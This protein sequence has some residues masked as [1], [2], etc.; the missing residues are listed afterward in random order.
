[1][2]IKEH[3]INKKTDTR[4]SKLTHVIILVVLFL[5]IIYELIFPQNSSKENNNNRN[6]NNYNFIS[7]EKINL[8]INIIYY[9]LCFIRDLNQK[10]TK[11]SFQIYFHFC[12]SISASIP[13]IYLIKGIINL[14]ENNFYFNK[15]IISIILILS[16]FLLNIMETLIMKR[17]KPGYI[18]PIFLITFLSLYYCLIYFMGKMGIS[19]GEEE[20]KYIREFNYLMMM[21]AFNVIG[22][23]VGWW[24][25]KLV[26][27]P[28]IK[29]IDLKNN[30]DSSELSEE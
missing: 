21:Y 6:N 19:I 22:S 1:M 29:K 16:P 28:K 27:R 17:F 20:D 18:N 12:F 4:I 24:I 26:T 11:K 7:I 10:D 13:I 30:L 15:S 5:I 2:K 25:Y 9:F 8:Y 23:L 3:L 14:G